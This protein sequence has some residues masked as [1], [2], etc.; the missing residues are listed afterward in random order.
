[1]TGTELKQLRANLS[2]AIGRPLSAA[3]MARL[4]GLP[5]VGGADT[6]RRWEVTG[7]SEQ[8]DK[9]LRVLAMASERYPIHDTFNV[10]D[11]YDVREKDRP[12]R[13]AEFRER[14][15]EEVRRRLG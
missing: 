8:A 4:C 9:L 3:D 15:R 1:M 13:K 2:D 7:P 14:M 6:I 5:P 10:F 11:R 12:A